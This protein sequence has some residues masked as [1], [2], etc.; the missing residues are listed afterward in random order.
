MA[1][2]VTVT[3]DGAVVA[4]AVCAVALAAVHLTVGRWDAVPER[5]Y[6]GL[7]SAGGGASVAYV[8]VLILPE[9]GEE[10]ATVAAAGSGFLAEQAVFLVALVGFVAFYGVE[11]AV[12]RRGRAPVEADAVYWAH[13]AVFAAYSAVVG[14]LLFHQERQGLSNLLFYA[15]A[16]ALHF[17]V[18]D[19]GLHRHHGEA[20]DTGG[21]ALLA[22][23]TLLGA[24]V[25]AVTAV[26][27]VGL[28][29][30]FGFLAGAIVF[31]VVNEEVPEISEARFAAFVAGAALFSAVLLLA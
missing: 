11:V 2:Q 27:E 6:R 12:S 20:F 30:L 23:G 26:D 29:M 21:R 28:A 19:Y 8:F 3:V 1:L 24:L 17:A 7:L 16:M 15:L 31:T 4:A 10:A 13:V 14:Y 5:H 22:A 9:I 25:G 18:T